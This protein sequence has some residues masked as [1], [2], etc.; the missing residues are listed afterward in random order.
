MS[1]V[2]INGFQLLTLTRK[3]KIFQRGFIFKLNQNNHGKF[4]YFKT[5]NFN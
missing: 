1:M 5:L 4:T 2:A 3:A